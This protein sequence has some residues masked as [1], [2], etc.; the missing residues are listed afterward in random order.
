[1]RHL[2]LASGAACTPGFDRF[3]GEEN[4]T[5][6]LFSKHQQ[7]LREHSAGSGED[8]DAAAKPK[9]AGKNK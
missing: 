7:Q 3:I 6:T 9:A 2:D 1:M 4:K 5:S 8:G